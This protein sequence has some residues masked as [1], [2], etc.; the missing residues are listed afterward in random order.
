M[1][2]LNSCEGLDEIYD[3]ME[4]FTGT[5]DDAHDDIVS[6]ISLLAE[7]F[8][9]YADVDS[10]MN[11][12]NQDYVSDM[13]SKEI[14]DKVYCL[15]KYARF[16]QAG[17]DLNDNPKTAYEMINSS[18]QYVDEKYVDPLSDVFQ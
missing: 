16:N 7:Q 12:I 13:R 5:S 2:F 8:S 1:Y 6:A 4:K 9:G 17:M 3:E 14:H 18:P 11:S 15:G 10:R